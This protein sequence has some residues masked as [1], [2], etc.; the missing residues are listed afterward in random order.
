MRFSSDNRLKLFVCRYTTWFNI[1]LLQTYNIFSDWGG[2]V[3][4][5]CNIAEMC[6]EMMKSAFL[7]VISR[8]KEISIFDLH[9]LI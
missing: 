4:P 1:L 2:S 5:S 3:I 7:F 6:L 8:P 9:F